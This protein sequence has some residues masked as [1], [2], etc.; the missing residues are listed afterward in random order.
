MNSN[1]RAKDSSPPPPRGSGIPALPLQTLG[2]SLGYLN[3][4]YTL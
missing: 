4:K 3:N 2:M 1:Q